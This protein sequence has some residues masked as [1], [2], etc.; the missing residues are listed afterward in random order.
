MRA[1]FAIDILKLR[2]QIESELMVAGNKL[3]IS[4]G[5]A[6]LNKQSAY[7]VRDVT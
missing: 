2:V 3:V 6:K 7:L 5:G 1:H 4:W